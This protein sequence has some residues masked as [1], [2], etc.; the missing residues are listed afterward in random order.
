MNHIRIS[1]NLSVLTVMTATIITPLFS[2]EPILWVKEVILVAI[3][4]A[5][6]LIYFLNRK[7]FT[8]ANR[9][10]KY[11]SLGITLGLLL[12]FLFS[13]NDPGVWLWGYFG[14]ANGSL[15][16]I[17]LLVVLF[18]NFIVQDEVHTRRLLRAIIIAGSLNAVYMVVQLAD[19]DPIAWISKETF[20]FLGN[21][22]FSSALIGIFCIIIFWQITF[23]GKLLPAL[24]KTA[25]V[26][27]LLYLIWQSGSLQGLLM[28]AIGVQ[29]RLIQKVINHPW[30]K[31]RTI[32]KILLIAPQLLAPYF[33]IFMLSVPSLLD[34]RFFQE[35]IQFRK[36]YW[37]AAFAMFKDYPIFGVGIDNYGNYYRSFRSITASQ[38]FDRVSNS[39]HSIFLDLLS[40]G[41]ITLFLPYFLL[42]IYISVC[43]IKVFVRNESLTDGLLV[44]LWFACQIQNLIG[45]QT[46]SL[47]VI[48]WT[49][50]GLL[51]ARSNL[52]LFPNNKEDA[53]YLLSSRS[54]KFSQTSKSKFSVVNLQT[55]PTHLI[56]PKTYLFSGLLFLSGILVTSP[57]L[58]ADISFNNQLEK[59]NL[60]AM[61]KI[62]SGKFGN[63]VLLSVTL[64]KATTRED[65]RV[66][67]Q[68]A[69]MLTEKY[70]RS[71]YGW[72]VISRL[73]VTPDALRDKAMRELLL[74]E[75]RFTK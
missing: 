2:F 37:F 6:F 24:V 13:R 8:I 64:E 67:L 50:A 49:I 1:K 72:D 38:D 18:L 41:G 3:S 17:S 21:I 51:L 33:V 54:K 23:M 69:M 25:F 15:T 46:I 43:A 12:N 7:Q 19:Q 35:T 44:S 29:F 40:G 34:G 9:S 36:D 63:Q 59:N 75:P 20:G 57:P 52:Q 56:S 5:T 61:T 32:L 22:N 71:Y 66:A 28:F 10:V 74:L 47:G 11:I 62:A 48:N 4:F 55:S 16:Y 68:I 26:C 60:D 73:K 14:R 53:N 45:I 42:T 65:G 58:I 39:A 31:S 27:A 30:L 70:P